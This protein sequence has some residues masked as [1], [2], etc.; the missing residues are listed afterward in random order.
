MA[1]PNRWTASKSISQRYRRGAGH[2]LG[3][4]PSLAWSGF[5]L[6]AGLASDEGEHRSPLHSYMPCPLLK[7]TAF[8]QAHRAAGGALVGGASG[9]EVAGHFQEMSAD[10]VEAVVFGQ[11]AGQGFEHRK[12][13]F[14]SANHRDGDCV[15]ESH[16]RV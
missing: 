14:W 6:D 12:P 13:G 16:H 10:S 8:R 5:I 11:F 15:V 7:V 9:G 2:P 3:D 1:P 4:A